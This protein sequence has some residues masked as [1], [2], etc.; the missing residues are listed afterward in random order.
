VL[1]KPLRV[2]FSNEA[3]DDVD[4]PVDWYIGERALVAA[5]NFADE[6]NQPL[7][8]LSDQA[9]SGRLCT[10]RGAID[11]ATVAVAAHENL[12]PTAGTQEESS[13]RFHRRTKSRQQDIDKAVP[14]VNHPPC[15]RARH[16]VEHDIGLDL[17]V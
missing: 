14:I 16:D 6:L 12:R 7:A 9:T 1:A 17:A 5:D 11:P 15:T 4:A 8:R 2:R 13:R 10:S 3:Q